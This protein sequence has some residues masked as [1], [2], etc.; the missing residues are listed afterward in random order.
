MLRKTCPKCKTRKSVCSFGKKKTR[1]DGLQYWCRSCC[2]IYAKAYRKKDPGKARAWVRKS[3]LKR[4]YG[5]SIDGYN[6]MFVTQN[7]LCA[8]CGKPESAVINSKVKQ[9]AVDHN[10]QTGQVRGLLCQ[11]CNIRLAY[12]E[13]I[14]FVFQA[15]EYL[16]KYD[17]I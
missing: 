7:G 16:S 2:S 14:E 9:L 11:V 10:H 17:S 15:K 3:E 5:L 13:N 4:D 1:V 12:I 6:K 8:I